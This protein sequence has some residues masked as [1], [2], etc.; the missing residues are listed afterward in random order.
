MAFL[1]RPGQKGRAT[2][3]SHSEAARNITGTFLVLRALSGDTAVE[4][5]ERED[6][7]VVV[8]ALQIVPGTSSVETDL[9]TSHK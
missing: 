6:V 2:I 9:M 1:R 5:A 7:P 4:R 3:T 8:P